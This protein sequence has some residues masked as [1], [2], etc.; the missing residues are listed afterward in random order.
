MGLSDIASADELSQIHRATTG[1]HAAFAAL[2]RRYE[3]RIH[4]YLR[5]MVGDAETAS[6]LTQET[7]LAAYRAL[8]RWQPPPETAAGTTTRATDLLSPWLYRIATNRALS[9]LRSQATH[10]RTPQQPLT[11]G[12]S[13]LE[14]TVIGRELLRAALNTLDD[15]DTVCLVLHYVAGERYGEIATRLNL[16]SEAV[17]KRVGRAL[18]ALRRAYAALETEAQ[19]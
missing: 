4:G 9:L 18:T 12:G 11:S 8:A 6:D 5:Q 19:Q 17:R 14:D 15:D 10:S 1:D 2:V 16:S 7:F 3:Q 13:S